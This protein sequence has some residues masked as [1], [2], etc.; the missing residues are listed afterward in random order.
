MSCEPV[1]MFLFVCLQP[2]ESNFDADRT[3]VEHR[4]VVGYMSVRFS[5]DVV[6][7]IQGKEESGRVGVSVQSHHPVANHSIGGPWSAQPVLRACVVNSDVVAASWTTVDS[8]VGDC[9]TL[10]SAQEATNR[11]Q[12]MWFTLKLTLTEISAN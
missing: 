11:L 7:V 2:L 5:P 10:S 4:N 12:V 9:S 3:V 1:L 8:D 6:R